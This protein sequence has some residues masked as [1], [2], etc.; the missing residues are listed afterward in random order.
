MLPNF[1]IIGSQKAGTTTLYHYLAK[2]SDIFMSQTK[3]INFFFRDDYYRKGLPWYEQHFNNWQQQSAVGE[4]SPG[5]IVSPQ[6]AE[7]IKSS[8]PQVKLILTVREPVGRAYSQYWHSRRN[9]SEH[10]SFK[11]VTSEKVSSQ[12]LSSERGYFSR[13]AYSKYLSHYWQ[14]FSKEDILVIPFEEL[15]KEP[16]QMLGSIC[17]FLNISISGFTENDMIPTVHNP[18]QI[19]QNPMYTLLFMNPKLLKYC[20]HLIR[21]LAKKG[22]KTKYD[23]PPMDSEIR[24]SLNQFYKPYNDELRELTGLSLEN[25]A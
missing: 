10:R 23:Y 5:Y 15:I 9:L 13:G 7:R 6:A 8:L 4:A 12:W 21:R 25:W 1:L 19:P 14:W 20:P 22:K 18:S 17:R 3:E 16:K 24:E 11:E 2:H